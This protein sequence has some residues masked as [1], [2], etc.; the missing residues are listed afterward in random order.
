MRQQLNLGMAEPV[1]R[2]DSVRERAISRQMGMV[3]WGPRPLLVYA[4]RSALAT[5]ERHQLL[6]EWHMHPRPG[7][8]HPPAHGRNA[9]HHRGNCWQSR[10]NCCYQCD[11]RGHFIHDSWTPP[12]R[13]QG[14]S[15][16]GRGRPVGHTRQPAVITTLNASLAPFIELTIAHKQIAS[17]LYTGAS[18]SLFVDEV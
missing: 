7:E 2:V 12:S 6:L 4:R 14:R 11:E 13:D 9:S 18:A 1:S 17:L 10:S 5:A 15:G 8:Q 16:N 3:P